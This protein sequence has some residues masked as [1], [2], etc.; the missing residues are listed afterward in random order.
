M[1]YRRR[2][3]ER[4]EYYRI[5]EANFEEFERKYSDMNVSPSIMASIA[6]RIAA[7]RRG[8]ILMRQQW[9]MYIFMMRSMSINLIKKSSSK[10]HRIPSS[11]NRQILTLLDNLGK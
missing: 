4:S 5:I 8:K 7:K 10:V 11:K 2:H 9:R 1:I 3:T 6:A